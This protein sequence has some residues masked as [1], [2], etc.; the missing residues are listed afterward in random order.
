M[1]LVGIDL[2]M[3][4]L[5]LGLRPGERARALESGRVTIVVGEIERLFSSRRNQRRERD[6]HG[7]A[8]GDAHAT[9]ETDDRIQYRARRVR[10]RKTVDH[11]HGGTGRA[12]A[13]EEACA[14]GLE[15][16]LAHGIAFYAD[17]IS[18]PH[19]TLAC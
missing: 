14:V 2:E 10:E 1:R 18:R 15:L 6:A 8:G 13:A 19:L 3:M 5:H 16:D 17:D 9:S 12:P 7:G 4:K 11:R